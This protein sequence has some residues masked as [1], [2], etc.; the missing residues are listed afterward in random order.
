MA[1]SIQLD[2]SERDLAPFH[3]ALAA[4]RNAVANQPVAGI[5]ESARQHLAA[6][7][8]GNMPDFVAERLD[9]LEVLIAMASDDAWGLSAEELEPILTALAYFAGPRNL[10]HDSVPVFGY[11]DDALAIELVSRP[12]RHEIDAY[13]D[14]CEYRQAEAQRRNLDPSTVGRADWLMARRE[15][16]IDRMH[17]RRHRQV[18]EGYGQSSGYARRSYL[19]QIWRPGSF[20]R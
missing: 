4:A 10:I 13:D 20:L 8:S 19:T 16:L 11:V 14:F 17:G 2:F 15:E 12:L 3:T 7:R 1:F 9:L 5:V 18:G 6:V